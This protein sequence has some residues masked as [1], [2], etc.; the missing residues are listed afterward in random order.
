MREP[1]RLAPAT[2]RPRFSSA[3]PAIGA[4]LLAFVGACALAQIDPVSRNLL[5]LGYDQPLVGHGPQSGYAYYYYNRPDYFGPNIALRAA[6]APAYLDSEIGFKNLLSPTTDLGIGVY[7]GAFGDNFYD[8]VQGQY[9]ETQSFYGSGGGATLGIYQR[10]NPHQRIPLNLITRGGLRYATYFDMPQTA[11]E[12][13]LPQDQLRGFTRVGLQLAGPQPLL[14]PAFGLEV[15]AWFERQ[16]HFDADRYGFD[17]DRSIAPSTDLYW[18]DARLNW[19]FKAN[20]DR[21]SFATTVGGSTDADLFSAWRLGGVLPLSSEFPLMLPGYYYEELTA[22]R[23]TYFYGSYSIP[24]DPARRWNFR[25][26]AGTARLDYLPGYAQPENWQSGA[27]AGLSFAP[28]RHAYKIVLRYGYG[29]DA[30]RH[31]R[32]G[33]QSVGLLFQYN[34]NFK[35]EKSTPGE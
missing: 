28:P 4:C 20:G 1:H 23:F 27:G 22:V 18:F 3:L 9:R 6:I 19:E 13:K 14:M 33:G 16:W 2:A 15:S 30:I 25:L 35:K 12:F 26:D 5:E 24:L 29:F 11:P 10:L 7:G 21:L 32:E 8:I 34:F 17:G 31:G